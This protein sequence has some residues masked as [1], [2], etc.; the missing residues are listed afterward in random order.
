M[1]LRANSTNSARAKEVS[2]ALSE[3]SSSIFGIRRKIANVRS[4]QEKQKLLLSSDTGHF[5][6]IKYYFLNYVL[7][8]AS[9]NPI[10]RALHL[11]D[12]I[13]ELNGLA[14]LLDFQSSTPAEYSFRV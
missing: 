14:L 8:R 1:S 13:T 4:G 5:S 9:F 3:G 6:L 10:Y 2:S 12:L 11:A 7:R